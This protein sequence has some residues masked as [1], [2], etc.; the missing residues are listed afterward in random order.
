MPKP[1][2][3]TFKM[4]TGSDWY[5]PKKTTY[6]EHFVALFRRNPK[7]QFF[8]GQWLLQ[9]DYEGDAPMEKRWRLETT[10]HVFVLDFRAFTSYQKAGR[11]RIP[12]G[13]RHEYRVECKVTDK[14][15]KPSPPGSLCRRNETTYTI[16]QK[17][18][19]GENIEREHK[20][21]DIVRAKVNRAFGIEMGEFDFRYR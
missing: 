9:R 17:A 14:R 2:P 11:L 12:S 4:P 13:T 19:I 21:R 16:F 8:P 5:G 6:L 7:F 1:K 20:A 10:T 3:L 18:V 15:I